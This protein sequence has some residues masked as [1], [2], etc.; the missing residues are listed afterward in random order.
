MRITRFI[1]TYLKPSG[2]RWVSLCN[3]VD[4]IHPEYI[5]TS[6]FR[7]WK[8]TQTARNFVSNFV[9]YFLSKA[10]WQSTGDV[11]ATESNQMNPETAVAVAEVTA[12]GL[13]SDLIPKR[14]RRRRARTDWCLSHSLLSDIS[15]R[16]S[17]AT[18]PGKFF[19]SESLSSISNVDNLYWK[20]S[21]APATTRNLRCD[22]LQF[23][24]YRLMGGIG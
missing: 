3:D 20:H 21:S 16:M 2:I 17:N 12:V 6:T 18:N 11:A 13:P 1:C 19:A 14:C 4:V 10:L 5:A 7:I 15:N 8:C 9:S 23:S 24:L 22:L